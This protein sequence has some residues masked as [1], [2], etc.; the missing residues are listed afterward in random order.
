MLLALLACSG[1]DD[2]GASFRHVEEA[3]P[4]SVPTLG[5]RRGVGPDSQPAVEVHLLLPQTV[6][7]AVAR[8]TLQ[9]AIDSVAQAD[10]SVMWMK[11]IGFML[12]AI[13]PST[14]SAPVEPVLTAYWAPVD[15]ADAAIRGRNARFM[16]NFVAS[17]PLPEG[18]EGIG[19]R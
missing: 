19:G 8:A 14:S 5:T 12:G 15:T 4:V 17:R 10:S 3:E 7:A 11:V 1:N 13:D 18:S 6:T 16:T 2:S 9:H